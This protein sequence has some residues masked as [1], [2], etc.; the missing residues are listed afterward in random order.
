MVIFQEAESRATGTVTGKVYANYIRAGGH[1]CIAVMIIF[2]LVISQTIATCSDLFLS[3]WVD[4]AE[5]NVSI[6][7]ERS[8][9]KDFE[10]FTNRSFL[11]YPTGRFN[12]MGQLAFAGYMPV[13][14][15]RFDNSNRRDGPRAFGILLPFL[16]A[17]VQTSPRHYV[18]GC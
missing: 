14:I 18:P 8:F 16:H 6:A 15:Q 17:G 5:A 13:H 3:L 12:G 10:I 7:S 1:W 2:L 9:D 4:L 11:R